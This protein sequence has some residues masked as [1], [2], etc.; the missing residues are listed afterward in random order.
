MLAGSRVVGK[1]ALPSDKQWYVALDNIRFGFYPS[2][3]AGLLIGEPPPDQHGS[4]GQRE[5]F[6]VA[7]C[8]FHL[9]LRVKQLSLLFVI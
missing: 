1:P 7:Q 2:V 5:D 6:R 3:D 9:L 8:P 4:H